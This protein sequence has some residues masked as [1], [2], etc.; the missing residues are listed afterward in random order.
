MIERGE[1]R[2][3]LYYRLNVFPITIPPLRDRGNDVIALAD[4]FLTRFAKDMGRG[5]KRLSTPAINM[6]L[7]YHWPGHVRELENVIER[8]ILLSDDDAIHGYHLPPSLQTPIV[9]A[10][11]PAGHR[12][13]A[14]PIRPRP[15]VGLRPYRPGPR[16]VR[17]SWPDRNLS[18]PTGPS[19]LAP[20]AI[21]AAGAPSPLVGEG[22]GGG[23]RPTN[24]GQ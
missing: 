7:S 3:D 12:A 10:A 17:P 6:L 21:L 9:P 8:A 13:A 22:W 15:C 11:A 16:V 2:E 4:H 5:V 1:F 20:H 23:V 18:G 14:A 19:G 24:Q